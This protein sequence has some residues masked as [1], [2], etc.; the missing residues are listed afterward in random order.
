M[1]A[2]PEKDS[3]MT[4]GEIIDK[5]VEAPNPFRWEAFDGSTAGPEDAKYTV[6]ILSP[7]GLS[8]IA[9]SPGD[10]GF[11]R[12]WVTGGMEVEG[13]HLAHP[14]GI[15]DTLRDL[16]GQFRKPSAGE[17]IKI[18]AALRRMGA[19]Q[20][21]PL[22][23]VER[24]S[25]LERS[26]RQGLSRHS[27]ERDADVI[28]AHY[29][30]GNE[31]YELFLGDTM[32]YTCAYYPSE[33]AGLDDA[34]INKYRL[35][36]EKLRLK[37]GDRLLDI[38]CGWGGMA[39]YAA[40]RGVHV[41]AVTLS[42][43]QAEWGRAAVAADGLGD[44]AEIRYQDYRDV[45]ESGFDAVSSIGLLEHVGVKNYADYFEFLSG[46]LRPGG[47]MLNHCITYP[48]NHKTR[49][50]EFID[51]YIFPDGE[52][53]GSGTVVRKMQDH[54]FEVLHEENLRFDYMRT[55]RDWCENLKANWDRAVDLVGLP[56]A[57]LWGMYMAGSEWG[58]EHNVVQLHQV[59]G[60]KLDEN[61]S[62]CGV[63][64][65]MWWRP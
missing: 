13:E 26:L 30:V 5:L 61:G 46:K 7:E 9:T 32:T 62:R 27:K 15:F 20:I 48:D 23:E 12:A 34:Q 35:V 1:T 40:R 52:L 6:R 51:R 42:Q 45:P 24:S 44:L 14:Y 25:F 55:L 56:T 57:K 63:P 8:Y 17:L 2:S 53:T 47:L 22:P 21:Q 43:E 64:E 49:K 10:V 33:D 36:F 28:S 50:G 59:L 29:D 60:V 65:R 54:G 39:R 58:F 4:V 18:Y 41:I 11:A 38:G 16:Y 19:L 37:E 3:T 31:F